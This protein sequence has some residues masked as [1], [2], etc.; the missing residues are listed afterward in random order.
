M[1]RKATIA[2][3]AHWIAAF[4]AMETERPDALF[5]DPFAARLAGSRG[6]DIAAA[7]TPD[8]ARMSWPPVMRT[9]LIDSLIEQS[10]T[11]GC[12]RVLNLA[13]GLD[14]RP[15]RLTLPNTL[16]W[17]EAD[18]PEIMNEKEGVL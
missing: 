11:E 1:E 17:I 8:M 5:R 9:K 16:V 14:T 15:Y 10:L 13:A 18:L 6:H 12:D 4:R 2:E 3:T 7:M